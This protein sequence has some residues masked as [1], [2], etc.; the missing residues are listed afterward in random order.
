MLEALRE[1]TPAGEPVRWPTCP[2]NSVFVQLEEQHLQHPVLRKRRVY[3]AA[4]FLASAGTQTVQLASARWIRSACACGSGQ[5]QAGECA[6]GAVAGV[7]DGATACEKGT[8]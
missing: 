2:L 1:W 3:L 7:C 4:S 8:I 6:A 5:A